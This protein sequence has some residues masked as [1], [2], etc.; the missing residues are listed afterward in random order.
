MAAVRSM[1]ARVARLEQARAPVLSPFEAMP[2]GLDGWDAQCRAGVD[3]G[4]LDAY[5][6][7]LVILAV[8]RWHRDR[9]WDR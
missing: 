6:I 1:L 4:N 9:I 8:R 7:P 3:A 2:G 5:D